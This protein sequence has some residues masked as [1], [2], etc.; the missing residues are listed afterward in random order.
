MTTTSEIRAEA[1]AVAKRYSSPNYQ[2]RRVEFQQ[3]AA[4]IIRGHFLRDFVRVAS[5]VLTD[6]AVF[7]SLGFFFRRRPGRIQ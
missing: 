2:S 1:V 3:R 6:V 7:A 5:L 4:K